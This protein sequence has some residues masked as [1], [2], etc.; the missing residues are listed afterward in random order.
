M[1]CTK[2]TFNGDLN[3]ITRTHIKDRA[4]LEQREVAVVSNT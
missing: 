2:L 3:W 4:L 1:T